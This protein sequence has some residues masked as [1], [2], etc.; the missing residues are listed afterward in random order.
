MNRMPK[1]TLAA[2]IT[3]SILASAV[4]LST[5]MPAFA[6]DSPELRGLDA[7]VKT[8]APLAEAATTD[9][10]SSAKS[11]VTFAPEPAPMPS[12]AASASGAP[13]TQSSALDAALQ[14]PAP[15]AMA[16]SSEPAAPATVPAT[17]GEALISSASTSN[18][19]NDNKSSDLA[20]APA[21][22]E[23]TDPQPV[24]SSADNK[25][26]A[27]AASGGTPRRLTDPM[28][29]KLPPTTGTLKLRRSFDRFPAQTLIHNLA[30]R[31][32]PV[33]E[34]IAEIARRGNLNTIIDKSCI[35]R[36]TGD[37]HD[38]TLNEAMDTI[39][40][41]SGLQWRQLDNSTIIIGSPGA[42]YNL[43]LNRPMMRVFKLS[44]AS[45]FDVAQMLWATTF[46]RGYLPD[47]TNAIRNRVTQLA[48]ETPQTKTV[49]ERVSG[50]SVPTPGG[51]TQTSKS[52]TTNTTTLDT[53]EE[54]ES[55][56]EITN[57]VR[58]DSARTIRGSIREQI[59]EGTGFNSGSVDPGSETIRA[60]NSVVT[61]FAVDQNGGGA[62]AIPD[63]KNRQ[64]IVCGTQDDIQ[65]AE[66]TIRLLDRRPRQ[67][68]IQSSLVEIN[69]AGIR[70]LGA[71]LNLQGAGA[72][73]T[74]LGG[75][76]APL[77]NFLP[78]L[79]SRQNLLY[80]GS[81]VV[82]QSVVNAIAGLAPLPLGFMGIGPLK[83]GGA[84]GAG[85]N[86]TTAS[87]TGLLTQVTPGT[88]QFD[89]T[90]PLTGNGFAGFIGQSLPIGR[91]TIAGVQANNASA[92]GFNFLTLSRRAG[93]RANIATVPVG[94]NL[95]LNLVLQTNK[96]K[97]LA[98]PSVVVN[99]NTEALITLA[100]EVVHKVTTTV[101]LG[102]VSTNVELVKAGIFLN[103]LPKVAEDGYITLRL[104]PQVS[105]P[106]G[107]P[108]EFANGSVV[109]TLLNVREVMTQEIR[110]KD[111]QTLVIGGLFT[112][113]E[114]ATL[115]K[116]PY[117]S[118]APILG[119]L[120]RNTLKGRN[121]TELMLLI[122][123][124]IVEDPPPNAMSDLGPTL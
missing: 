77:V 108:Q 65:V 78:G 21:P 68:H 93:G 1:G 115:A 90:V 24:S 3:A 117:V 75:S 69:N 95:T 99:D 8:L 40:S 11:S 71:A 29:N 111:G 44:Y 37:L 61:D 48:R 49:E 91:P 122:T 124:K 101:S 5:T 83:L 86:I 57:A 22:P 118:E 94:L 59:T 42:L 14:P 72:S 64:V 97:L 28:Y 87:G 13:A 47:F 15:P 16:T 20:I 58:P 116:V 121:R 76:G 10:N 84:Q 17:T 70:Q 113:Q 53:N 38:V 67:I 50:Q 79:G 98:N 25:E 100:N 112:E 27:Q 46:N 119:A 60:M 52:A 110:V 104:R 43:G 92:T 33:K 2:K 26:L 7:P 35:G 80:Q 23:V 89:T 30:F 32:T 55:G 102:V 120:F 107:G 74:V 109:V 85:A 34:V 54:N 62:I 73:S 36:I 66:E 103:V 31:D 56:Q 88:Q 19:T 41:S 12:A 18:L 81:G 45:P 4:L 123:P 63:V 106:L 114:A 96:A 39:L 105:S 6:S 82:G 9:G 51:G